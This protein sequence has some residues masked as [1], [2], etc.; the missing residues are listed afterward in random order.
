MR[1]FEINAEARG[2]RGRFLSLLG[3]VAACLLGAAKAQA[4]EPDENANWL[5]LKPLLFGERP[6]QG[7]AVDVLKLYVNQRADDAAVVPV[8][9][10][11][12]INQ[13]P[14]RYI[15]HIYVIIDENPSPFGVKFTMTPQSGR[16]DIETRVRM[17][18]SSPIRAIAEMNDGSLWMDSAMVYGAG[19]CSAPISGGPVDPS[20]GKM[21][22]SMDNML[23]E[24]GEPVPAQLM[25][26]HP[27]ITGMSTN[28]ILEPHFVR[29][30]NVYY[31]DQLVM[32][33]DVD[34]TISENP[35]FRFYFLPEDDGELR[36]EVV[37]SSD[38]RFE[39]RIAVTTVK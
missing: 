11:T 21:R 18:S 35:V 14:D 3:L 29:Q 26:K 28:V 17:E 19:G 25:I 27:Q 33:A 32:S 30:V 24:A 34:F 23:S 22:L 31:S 1:Y 6:I 7:H 37:D 16:A 38:L 20:L 12:Y 5:Q 8:M 13:K 15:K 9:V 36:A 2:M 39:Q 10:R 4:V